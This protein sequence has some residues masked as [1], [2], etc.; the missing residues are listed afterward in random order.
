[1]GGKI[2]ILKMFG[3][4][5]EPFNYLNYKFNRKHVFHKYSDEFKLHIK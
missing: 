5:T 2:N 1:M 3:S 4:F